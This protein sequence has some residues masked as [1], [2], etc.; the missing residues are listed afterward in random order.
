MIYAPRIGNGFESAAPGT[1]GVREDPGRI[2][3]QRSTLKWGQGRYRHQTKTLRITRSVFFCV[4]EACVKHEKKHFG[5]IYE[6]CEKH[7]KTGQMLTDASFLT[8]I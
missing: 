4:F 6:A 8:K 2:D 1:V 7:P 5:S 3:A